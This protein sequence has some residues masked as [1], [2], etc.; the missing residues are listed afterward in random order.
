M[1]DE[2]DFVQD[3]RALLNRLPD[4]TGDMARLAHRLNMAVDALDAIQTH[5]MANNKVSAEKL[6][7]IF[8]DLE[9]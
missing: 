6:K 7:D 1:Y 5:L 3:S 9:L 2:K 8:R 4:C